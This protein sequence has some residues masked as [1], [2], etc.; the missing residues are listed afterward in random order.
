[1]SIMDRLRGKEN[2]TSPVV[3]HPLQADTENWAD[4]IKNDLDRKSVV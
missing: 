3:R 4:L 2:I 1:M